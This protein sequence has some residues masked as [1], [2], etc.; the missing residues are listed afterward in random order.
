MQFEGKN[1]N[2]HVCAMMPDGGERG[3]GLRNMMLCIKKGPKS[4]N[5][6]DEQSFVKSCRN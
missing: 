5:I 1:L 6:V 4:S 2:E 3:G